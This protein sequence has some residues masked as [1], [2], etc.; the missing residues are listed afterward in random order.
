ED[1]EITLAKGQLTIRGSIKD[2]APEGEGV[3]THRR[4]RV[5]G[6]FVRT[7]GLPFEV[8]DGGISASYENGVL[9][10]TLPRAERSKPKTIPINVN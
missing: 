8:E 2:D 1:L 6:K 5:T 4:E 3:V 9:E 10:V 7:V